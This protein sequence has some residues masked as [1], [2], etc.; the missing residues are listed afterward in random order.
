MDWTVVKA[1]G[2]ILKHHGVPACIVGELVLN[3]YNVPRVCNVGA[4]KCVEQTNGTPIM[5]IMKLIYRTE[6][7]G[8]ANL[9]SQIQLC[10]RSRF[11]MFHRSF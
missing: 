2:L 8:I 10:R 9:C 5:V 1:A 6:L 7:L 11:A 3:Y 4:N